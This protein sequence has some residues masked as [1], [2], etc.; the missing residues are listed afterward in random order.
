MRITIETTVSDPVYSTKVMIEVP[1]DDVELEKVQLLM[2]DA[3][4]GF[5][6]R[7]VE[8]AAKE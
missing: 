5:G 1:Y 3:L 7:G 6:F 2:R 8:E 4:L